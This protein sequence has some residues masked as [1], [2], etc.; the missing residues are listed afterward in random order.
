MSR[1]I[2][3]AAVVTIFAAFVLGIQLA[4]LP[5]EGGPGPTFAPAGSCALTIAS[6]AYA[7]PGTLLQPGD[8][9]MLDQMTPPERVLATHDSS[10]VGDSASMVVLRDGR[11]TRLVE[12]VETPEPASYWAPSVAVKV[13]TFLVGLFLL[14]RGRDIA[15]LHYGIASAFFAIAIL[16]ISDALLSPAARN[17]YEAL[18]QIFAGISAYAL[19]LT[20]EDLARG[21]I[22]E[23]V[24]TA[25]RIAVGA[26]SLLFIANA[27][28]FSIGR[29]TNGCFEPAL[30]VMRYPALIIAL[31]VMIGVLTTT[32]VKATGL[33]RQRVRWVFWSTIVGFSG[34]VTWLVVPSFRAAVLTSVV[35]TIGYAYAILRHR[36]IDVGFV[37]NRAIVFTTVTTAVFAIFALV[38]TFVERLTLPVDEGVIVQSVVALALAFSFD[39]GFKRVESIID[40]VFFRDKHRAELALRRFTEEARYVRSAS[41]LLDGALRVV[42]ESLRAS[43]ACV[44]REHLDAYRNVAARGRTSFPEMVDGDDPAFVHL[45][46]GLKD[47]DLAGTAGALA[48][49]RYGF[50]LAAQRRLIGALI[51]GARDDA[52]AFDPE[53]RELVRALAREVGTALEVLDAADHLEFI[54][55]LAL[56]KTDGPAAREQAQALLARER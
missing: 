42:C 53:E 5:R 33:Q 15:S 1:R 39:F 52:E 37:I 3:V 28:D 40:Q 50:A 17:L 2:I 30:Y 29:S 34:V 46:A 4:S 25:C 16:P 12:S 49:D 31:A 43:A 7:R 9:L 6:V 41:V 54:E 26:S 27:V 20:F 14:W 38:S 56:G 11:T 48:G 10:A 44:Y 32:F 47:V 36:I 21:A 51:V 13:I 23:R 19:Y 45:R 55:Q 18:A 35:I 8:V 24:L 22:R